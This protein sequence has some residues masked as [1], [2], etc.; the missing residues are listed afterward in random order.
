M[1]ISQRGG[2]ISD[3]FPLAQRHPSFLRRSSR[4]R[5][6]ERD[7]AGTGPAGHRRFF[8]KAFDSNYCKSTLTLSNT[9]PAVKA[10][11]RPTWCC[12]SRS[13]VSVDLE[14]DDSTLPQHVHKD[15]H[16]HDHSGGHSLAH[17]DGDHRSVSGL[18]NNESAP[19]KAPHSS[20]G[21]CC[22]LMCVAALPATLIDLVTPSAPTAL[23]E[24]E[25]CRKA[26]DNAPPRLDRP[27]IS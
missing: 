25:G 18:L 26:A 13:A 24:V 10:S 11:A 7:R 22:G 6:A 9:K 21:Q 19:G 16:V 2:K 4:V 3:H 5:Q 23:C 14:D 8:G 17:S 15:G 20:H 27:P 1:E 12:M